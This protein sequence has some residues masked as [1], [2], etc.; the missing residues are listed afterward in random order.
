MAG[1]RY[2]GE[3]EADMRSGRGTVHTAAGRVWTGQWV[4][5][6]EANSVAT[7]VYPNGGQPLP[8]PGSKAAVAP[9]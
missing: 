2:V 8:W 7:C 1:D 6:R 3:W 4:Q 5:D 9:L